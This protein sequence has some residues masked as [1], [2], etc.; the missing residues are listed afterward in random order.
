MKRLLFFALAL[1]AFSCTREINQDAPVVPGAK[2]TIS[3]GIAETRTALGQP[4]GSVYP[5]LWSAGDMIAVNGVTS[6]PLGSEAAGASKASFTLT[7]VQ[8]PFRAVY[9]ASAA[10]NW[11]D[12][13]ATVTI[14]SRQTWQS[15]TYDPAAFVML[16]SSETESVSFSPAVP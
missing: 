2:V 7:G 1:L 12:G 6:E 14:P 8:A 13:A 5:N 11:S 16:G 3:A 9:P 4:E 10:S 15:G